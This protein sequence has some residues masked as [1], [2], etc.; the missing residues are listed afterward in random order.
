MQSAIP[1]TDSD[2]NFLV[3]EL[4]E[5]V[6]RGGKSLD[7]IPAM[8]KKLLKTGAWKRRRLRNGK[9]AEHN[10][11]YD[12]LT[13]RPLEGCGWD[14]NQIVS[15]IDKDVETLALWREAMTDKRG[16]DRERPDISNNNNIINRNRVKNLQGTSR[17][18]T[19]SRLKNQ[20]PDLFARV[21]SGELTPNQAAI[22]AGF[23]KRRT[24]LQQLRCAWAKATP[25]ER[26]EFLSDISEAACP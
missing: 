24:P 2:A 16:G 8:I 14:P 10:R 11:F 18:Y 6:S 7:Q 5:A 3:E 1:M 25:A 17:A 22:E 26:R 9:I 20:K 15:L 4:W 12:F 23:R 13:V 21:L 19:V